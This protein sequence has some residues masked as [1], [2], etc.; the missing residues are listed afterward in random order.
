VNQKNTSYWSQ[1]F[2]GLCIPKNKV[3]LRDMVLRHFESL[4]IGP[5]L[6]DDTLTGDTYLRMLNKEA[7][8]IHLFILHN[9]GHTEHLQ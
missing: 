5:L 4:I 6:F 7:F 8:R 1:D 9:G 3:S 2:T